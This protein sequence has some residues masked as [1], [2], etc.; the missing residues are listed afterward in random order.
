M[1]SCMENY[2]GADLS[3]WRA[4]LQHW[5]VTQPLVAQFVEA[6]QGREPWED[7]TVFVTYLR[8]VAADKSLKSYQKIKPSA[9]TGEA[10]TLFDA[11]H[12]MHEGQLLALLNDAIYVLKT[13][14]NPDED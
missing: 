11:P 8:A 2:G 14:P 6:A 9:L 7:L 5:N 1:Q 3:L 13:Q 4:H 12:K 10:L